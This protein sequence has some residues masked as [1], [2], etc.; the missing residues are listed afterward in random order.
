[1]CYYV[2][3][4]LDYKNNEASFAKTQKDSL[5]NVSWKSWKRFFNLFRHIKLRD[6]IW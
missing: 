6:L 4:L 1:M 3:I 5:V 2:N